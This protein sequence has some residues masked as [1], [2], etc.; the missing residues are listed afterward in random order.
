VGQRVR[1]RGGSLDGVEG[2]LTAHNG[3]QSLTISLEPI[4]RS[5]SIRI[6]GYSVEAA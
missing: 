4:Q 6:Q 3:D 5:I 2:V 1:V